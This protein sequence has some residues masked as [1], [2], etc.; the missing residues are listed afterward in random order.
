MCLVG[1]WD[2]G[3]QGGC[4]VGNSFVALNEYLIIGSESVSSSTVIANCWFL[5]AA[6]CDC[7]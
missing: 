5:G 7:W 6:I 1:N 2:D 4:K 3:A